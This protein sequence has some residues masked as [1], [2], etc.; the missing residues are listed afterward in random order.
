LNKKPPYVKKGQ[1]IIVLNSKYEEHK[2]RET[3][4]EKN[5]VKEKRETQDVPVKESHV[6]YGK[7]NQG[8]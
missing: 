8:I 7:G 6:N 5:Q 4:R 2:N 3:Y 1:K